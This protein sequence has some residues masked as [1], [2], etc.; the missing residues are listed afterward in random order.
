[1]DLNDEPANADAD[2]DVAG[3]A[4]VDS[5]HIEKAAWAMMDKAEMKLGLHKGKFSVLLPASSAR[6]LR[7][8]MRCCTTLTATP[9]IFLVRLPTHVF[10]I[11]TLA[12]RIS[13]SVCWQPMPCPTGHGTCPIAVN[14]DSRRRRTRPSSGMT[15]GVPPKHFIGIAGILTSPTGSVSHNPVSTRAT[16]L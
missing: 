6:L 16:C 11:M 1:M 4:P 2:T 7:S 13:S 3:G 10:P 5:R 12:A 15:T 9:M 14:S 8:L